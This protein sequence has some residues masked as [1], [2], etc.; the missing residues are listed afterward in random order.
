LRHGY[1][2]ATEGQEEV[3]EEQIKWLAEQLVDAEHRND[4]AADKEAWDDV[5]YTDGLKTAYGIALAKLAP[6]AHKTTIDKIKEHRNTK[7]ED[8][9]PLDE[10]A[11]NDK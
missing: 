7:W 8:Y 6:E 9:V 4:V 10:R 5:D 1:G 2:Q 3:T 11:T